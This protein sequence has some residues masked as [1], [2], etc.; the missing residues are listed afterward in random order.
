MDCEKRYSSKYARE[1]DGKSPHTIPCCTSEETEIECLNEPTNAL[2]FGDLSRID[3]IDKITT[4][5]RCLLNETLL[6]P[7][8]YKVNGK[9]WE[10]NFVDFTK[11]EDPF[12]KLGSQQ[13]TS[14]R[15]STKKVTLESGQT[16]KD[17][18]DSTENCNLYHKK[19][20][21]CYLYIHN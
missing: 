19:N 8:I 7:S 12:D 13:F 5:N 20:K 14:I 16:C 9:P 10:L 4:F 3:K 18:C 11:D 2:Q 15:C 21:D 17:I 1:L 6:E